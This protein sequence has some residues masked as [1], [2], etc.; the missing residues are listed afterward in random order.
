[1]W[2]RGRPVVIEATWPKALALG[3]AAGVTS[4]FAHAAGPIVGM[5]M[6]SLAMPKGRFVASVGLAFWAINHA[7]L[8]AYLHLGMIN[9]GTLGATVLLLPAIALG[10]AVGLALH[11]RLAQRQFTGVVYGLLALAGAGLVYDAVR[12]MAG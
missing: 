9:F 4:T 10:A 8:P 7:K 1:M 5:Y 11:R 6:L 2:R 3:A 12:A